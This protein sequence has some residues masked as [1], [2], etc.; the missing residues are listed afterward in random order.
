M[1]E[2]EKRR[3]SRGNLIHIADRLGQMELD[4]LCRIAERLHAGQMAYGELSPAKKH[5]SLEAQQEALDMAVY[6]SCL[7]EQRKVSGL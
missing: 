1:D 3:Q 4:V 5:W 7:L 6:L 2:C